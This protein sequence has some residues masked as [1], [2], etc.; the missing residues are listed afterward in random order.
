MIAVAERIYTVRPVAKVAA[1]EAIAEPPLP[2][3]TMRAERPTFELAR[4]QA[5]LWR[6]QHGGR[7]V[8]DKRR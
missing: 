3:G 6:L 7:V 8:E 4:A 5:R 2:D 1:F